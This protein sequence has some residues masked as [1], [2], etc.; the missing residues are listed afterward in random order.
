MSWSIKKGAAVVAWLILATSCAKEAT[1][2][3][4]NTDQITAL[5]ET[6]TTC[7]SHKDA[8]KL[9]ALWTEGGFFIDLT[10]S[11]SIQGRKAI[12]EYFK[13]RFQQGQESGREIS[14]LEI[15]F[16]DASH[17]TRYEQGTITYQDKSVE[18][19]RQKVEYV[20]KDGKWQI[21]KLTQ[22][23]QQ[24]TPS[25]FEELKQLGWF[26]GNWNDIDEN[27]DF[28]SS[29]KWG[30]N[31]NFLMRHFTLKVLDQQVMDGWEI[32]GWDAASK[33]IRSWLFDSDGGFG[34]GVWT[35]ESSSWYVNIAFSLPDGRH[36]SATH[37]Y[38]IVDDNSYT[39][40]AHGRDIE[41]QIFPDIGPY[42]VVRQKAVTP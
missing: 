27:V 15:K 11:K 10:M 31:Q 41:G 24:E 32:I 40:S 29:W 4:S 17:A 16:P 25:H 42:T 18:P 34:S 8:T 3:K 30:R 7:Y 2:E 19:C 1:D 20:K 6:Y 14:K 12:E 35:Q 38:T 9:A 13:G 36:G 21:E 5:E 39:F 23:C 37:V 26:V 22:I 28:A 33:Q